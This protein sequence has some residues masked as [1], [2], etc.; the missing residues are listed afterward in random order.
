MSFALYFASLPLALI[1]L[2]GVD[3]EHIATLVGLARYSVA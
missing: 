1:E 3:T 2:L